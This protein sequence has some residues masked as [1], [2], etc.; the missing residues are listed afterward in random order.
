MNVILVTQQPPDPFGN[1]AGRSHFALLKGLA[2]RGHQVQCFSACSPIENGERAARHALDAGARIGIYPHPPLGN[3]VTRRLALVRQPFSSFISDD[4]RRGVDVA[5]RRGYDV[6][7]LEQLW[8]GYLGVGM[9]R[10]LLSV[11]HLE[12][13]DLHGSGFRSFEF[14][15]A[16]MLAYRGERRML[17]R[18]GNI[19]LTTN[20]LTRVVREINANASLFTV[21]IALDPSL[22][23]FATPNGS[24]GTVG[25]IG[26]M[27]WEP[28]YNA[29]VR[30]INSVWPRVRR[31]RP[32]AT[33][34]VVGWQ[35]PEQLARFAGV[36]GLTLSGYIP[37]A[38]AFFRCCTVLAYPLSRGS[39]MK[40]KILEAMAYGVPVVT[41]TE[42]IE[43]VDAENGLHAFVEDDDERFAERVVELL[44]DRDRR[45]RM[46]RAARA[47]I[48]ERYSHEATVSRILDAYRKVVEQ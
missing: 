10:A 37:D 7:H 2:A 3:A 48:E 24:E 45:I 1:P 9:P 20:R 42:G 47:L 4:L 31:T 22:Y 40:V 14:F 16:K 32:A 15:K 12:L 38:A 30:L 18:F 25:L 26:G 27:T 5:C 36:S 39:G 46:T 41:T 8:T 44:S 11:H 28:G 19:R 35:A 6:L 33:L 29:A 23:A 34:S 13:L 17:P 21:P 43:G